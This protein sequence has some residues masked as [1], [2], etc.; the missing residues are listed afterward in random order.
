MR[1]EPTRSELLSTAISAARTGG[2]ILT[3]YF[4]GPGAGGSGLEVEHKS[5]NDLVSQ[6]DRESEAAIIERI[7]GDY[8][9][10]RVLGEES[11]WSGEPGEFEWILDPLD[12]TT[13]FLH[14]LPVYAVS[15][16]C[17][18]RGELVIGVVLEPETDRLFGAARGLG[19]TCNGR[20]KTPP[21]DSAAQR[22]SLRL[23]WS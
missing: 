7:L 8:P 17:R 4:R 3:G 23:R 15:V 16:A 9:D 20:P 12:G 14:G 2:E 11:G 13:N 18:H 22:P 10:H 21:G 1:S 6:A 19:A 5:K